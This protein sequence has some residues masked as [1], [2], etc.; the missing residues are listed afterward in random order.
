[1]FSRRCFE[2]VGPWDESFFLYSE[3]T[4]FCLRARDAG[5]RTRLVPEA[6]VVHREGGSGRSDSTHVMQI[7]NRVRLYARRHSTAAG[8]AYLALNV[9]SELTW[10]ARGQKQS[11]ASVRGLLRPRSRPSQ[12]G[13]GRE[14]LPR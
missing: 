1:M 2:A 8:Y 6:V 10:L 5:W 11:R 3:E 9:L 14:L 7:V 4:D 13:L 12:L